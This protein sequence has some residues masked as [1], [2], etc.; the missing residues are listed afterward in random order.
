MRILYILGPQGPD[1]N[2]STDFPIKRVRGFQTRNIKGG[3]S[4]LLMRKQRA[5]R[6]YVM[7]NCTA[8]AQGT[9]TLQRTY[10]M[11]G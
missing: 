7:Q 5:A 11:N 9:Y 2:F 6:H 10:F 4:L 1:D 3:W 8:T